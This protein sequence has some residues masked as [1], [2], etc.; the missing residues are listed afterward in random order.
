MT[1]WG[2]RFSISVSYYA[3]VP[4]P[5]HGHN[6][7]KPPTSLH[8]QVLAFATFDLAVAER[9]WRLNNAEKWMPAGGTEPDVSDVL[10]TVHQNA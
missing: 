5:H 8:G 6:P 10:R 2:E 7:D 4:K 9:R 1:E 3:P